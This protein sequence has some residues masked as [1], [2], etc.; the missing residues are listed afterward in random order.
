[1]LP[2]HFPLLPSLVHLVLD[3][4]SSDYPI[5]GLWLLNDAL[6]NMPEIEHVE[7]GIIVCMG[8]NFR[9]PNPRITP[10]TVPRLRRLILKSRDLEVAQL[11]AYLEMPHTASV[12]SVYYNDCD[13]IDARDYLHL[14]PLHAHASLISAI[15]RLHM[16]FK[17]SYSRDG[18]AY[19]LS[20]GAGVGAPNVNSPLP[21]LHL[22]V[23]WV[24]YTMT[25]HIT[26]L[27]FL[28]LHQI[29]HLN[30]NH[31]RDDHIRV[32]WSSLLP[33]LIRLQTITVDHK[34]ILF[35][36]STKSSRSNQLPNPELRSV[37]IVN[38]FDMSADNAQNWGS[39]A[40]V[41]R[42]RSNRGVPIRELTVTNCSVTSGYLEPLKR[43]T[44][45]VWDGKQR[46]VTAMDRMIRD[47]VIVREERR[48]G[49][50]SDCSL[51]DVDE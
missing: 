34:P 24:P 13:D 6:R 33:L 26:T 42:S 4:L 30:I 28:P 47:M 8:L 38:D 22:Q 21:F 50:D 7:V 12:S 5:T 45:V 51:S 37:Y 41:F 15:N 1:M 36:L 17:Q 2:S 44:T 40:R 9:E 10:V 32:P 23:E 43:F 31:V 29:Q 16:Q 39:L 14:Q 11:F 19:S 49:M 27:R 25:N 48:S 46:G 18:Y 35:A 3:S 20:V